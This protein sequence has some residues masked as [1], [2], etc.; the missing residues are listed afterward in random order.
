MTEP[1]L[2]ASPPGYALHTKRGYH[3]V[4]GAWTQEATYIAAQPTTLEGVVV[5]VCNGPDTDTI[6]ISGTAG[7]A[8]ISARGW[9]WIRCRADDAL[10]IVARRVLTETDIVRGRAAQTFLVR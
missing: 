5:Q 9:T 6:C 1:V 8:T 2:L 7:D 3:P 10:V 4:T